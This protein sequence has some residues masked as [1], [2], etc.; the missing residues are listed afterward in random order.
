ME[1]EYVFSLDT[2]LQVRW[3]RFI[4]SSSCYYGYSCEGLG[5]L[6]G[7][8]SIPSFCSG[9][10][11]GTGRLQQ[12]DASSGNTA[13]SVVNDD[14]TYYDTHAGPHGL[15]YVGNE[16]ANGCP[17]EDNNPGY[18][19]IKLLDGRNDDRVLFS[20]YGFHF[21]RVAQA[22]NGN[23]YVFGDSFSGDPH[24]QG[25]P[26]E[27]GYIL[28][29]MQGPPA[30]YEFG[31]PQPGQ[32]SAYPNPSSDYVEIVNEKMIEELT[33]MNGSGAII[34]QVRPEAKSWTIRDLRPG[35]YF[36]R[37]KDPGGFHSGKIVVVSR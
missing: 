30:S 34:A 3:S 36:V 20:K 4:I 35:C 19:R 16:E 33:V 23:I 22:P 10:Y 7:K 14:G 2:S 11:G 21:Y 29:A 37:I 17:C 32:L 24:L 27:R 12:L 15:L 6:G 5:I 25:R 13:W 18:A 8:A 1:G 31:L 9:K 28:F 26:L